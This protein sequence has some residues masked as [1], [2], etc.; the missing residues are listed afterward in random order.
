MADVR[1]ED[2]KKEIIKI[3]QTPKLK[4]ISTKKI[5]QKLEEVFGTDLTKKKKILHKLIMD[6]VNGKVSEES[7][8]ESSEESEE[9]KKPAKRKKR[10]YSY[11][12]T[13]SDSDEDTMIYIKRRVSTELVSMAELD[14]PMRPPKRYAPE[15]DSS[16]E[17]DGSA[18]S[19]S[20]E[21]KKKP[22]AKKGKKK[23][24]LDVKDSDRGKKKAG[25]GGRGKG[26][27]YTR[28]CKLSPALAELMGQEQMPRHE[29]VKRVWAI[30]K[31]KNL[32]DPNNKQFAICDD[33]LYKV[34]GTQR[35]RTFG[36]MKY[37]KAHF[38]D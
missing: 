35:F 23:K 7:E 37:L 36:M 6:H 26:G 16:D 22:A 30:V 4:K 17:E 20:E 14:E 38:L 24:G 13:S 21:E 32:Y 33:A 12:E 9:D 5:I 29:V 28:A 3:L 1:K 2:L 8:S 19:E 25:A 15:L 34:I 11:D 10:K 18:D 31:E 27:G